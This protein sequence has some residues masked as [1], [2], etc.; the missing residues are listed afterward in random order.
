MNGKTKMV[1]SLLRRFSMVRVAITAGTLQPK[2]IIRG[3]KDLPCRP[4]LCI[5]LSM[6][7]AARA[8]YPESS[9]KDINVYNISIWGKN[10]IT[11]PTPAMA[12]STIIS[13]NGPTGNSE[14]MMLLMASTPA[15]IQS[16]GYCPRVNVTSNMI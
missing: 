4:I 10:T 3:M 9:I 2:P 14:D 12:P 7:K 15:S 5:T 8:I 13:L 1:I 16:I 6:I 11:A